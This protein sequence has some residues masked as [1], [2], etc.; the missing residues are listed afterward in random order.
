[1]NRRA[2]TPLHLLTRR[3]VCGLL[4]LLLVVCVATSS[5]AG[6]SVPPPLRSAILLKAAG[7]ENGLAQRSG[8][9]V[10][11]VVQ[12]S[13]GASLQDGKAVAA[14]LI[15]LLKKTRIGGRPGHVVQIT[16][17]SSDETATKLREQKAEVIYFAAGL[18]GIA[19]E[20][21]AKEGSVRRIVACSDGSQVKDGCVLGVELDGEKPRLVVN[22]KRANAVGL[23][24]QPELLR[25]A[26]I[27]R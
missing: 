16:H 13:S 22:L 20:V 3:F 19:A 1:M 7:Y 15:A 26:R 10:I 12:G 11:A 14:T 9:V 4:G 18:E 5:A 2:C 21:P 23:R 6:Q 24:F 17:A 8:D 27:V 25:L